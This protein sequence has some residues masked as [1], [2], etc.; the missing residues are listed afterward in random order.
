MYGAIIGDL[1]GSIYE[2]PEFNDT[3]KNKIN[4]ERRLEIFKTKLI[5]D[6]SFYSDDTILTIAILDAVLNNKNYEKMLRYYGNLY[7]DKVP[8]NIP[9]FKYMF[10]PTFV[11]WLNGKSIGN[12]T[13][14]GALMRVSAIAYLYDD[15]D[16]IIE[17][18]FLSAIP[19]H[20]NKELFESLKILVSI[21]YYGRCGYSLTKIQNIIREFYNINLDY[22]LENL[23]RTNIFDGTHKV[24]S[25]CAYILFN[26]SDFEDAIRKI[27][28]IGGDTDTLACITG[29]MAESIY[30]IPKYLKEEVKKYLPNEFNN[31]LDRGYKKIKIM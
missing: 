9:Y 2:Y 3:L 18:T 19:T 1:A 16:K 24:I 8:Q 15:L 21:I 13:G 30:E 17:E 11:K 12:S 27:I 14:N 22:N 7:K 4:L 29:M 5:S 23:Q 20:N 10:S 26:S 31:L 28:S 6:N 25:K